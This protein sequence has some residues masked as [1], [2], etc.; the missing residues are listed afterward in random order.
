MER[1][2]RSYKKSSNSPFARRSFRAQVRTSDVHIMELNSEAF[3]F[4]MMERMVEEDVVGHTEAVVSTL[5]YQVYYEIVK[6]L[7]KK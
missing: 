2:S 7:I 6:E 1:V 3:E 4:L 5:K